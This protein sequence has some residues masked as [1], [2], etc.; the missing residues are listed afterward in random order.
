VAT[1]SVTANRKRLHIEEYIVRVMVRKNG[2]IGDVDTIQKTKCRRFKLNE[3]GMSLMTVTSQLHQRLA[4]STNKHI[5]PGSDPDIMEGE[6]T[7]S[8]SLPMKAFGRATQS[9]SSYGDASRLRCDA[10]LKY[11][12]EK[13]I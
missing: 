8:Y 4:Q 11:G 1:T 9:L 2:K 6:P 3:G 5:K 7:R 10:I 12:I 13:G